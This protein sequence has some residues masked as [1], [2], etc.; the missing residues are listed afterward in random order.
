[1]DDDN[2]RWRPRIPFGRRKSGWFTACAGV[3][4]T[5]GIV[6]PA[7]AALVTRL[8]GGAV[9]DTDLN[10]TWL[11]DANL[12]ASN[13]FGVSGI[14]TGSSP[15]RM[16]WA[17][18]QTWL[19]AMNAANYLGFNDWRLPLTIA[20]DSTCDVPSSATGYDCTGSEMGHLFYVE[21]SG[22]R[23]NDILTSGDPDL[24]KFHNIRS[25]YYWS[26]DYT[27]SSATTDAWEFTF[28]SGQ[29]AGI[30]KS[31]SN[32][33]WAVRT[34]DVVVPLPAAGWL[35]ATGLIVLLGISWKYRAEARTAS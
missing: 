9:Y 26:T 24:A 4:L 34:G 33:V 20:P 29:Q 15:G 10:I 7:E 31:V 25:N 1:M 21:L 13:T 30:S 11:A 17:T 5:L 14:T 18:A 28:F 23:G 27:P 6:T 12:A 32:N 19:A 8:S 16:T 35:M 22:T 2:N 3:A